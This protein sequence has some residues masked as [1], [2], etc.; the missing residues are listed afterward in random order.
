MSLTLTTRRLLAAF[1]T[2]LVPFLI[3]VPFY[4]RDG[5]PVIDISLFKS[6]MIVVSSVVGAILIVWVF[7][8]VEFGYVREAIVTGIVWLIA[9]WALD[10]IVLVGMFG[11]NPGEWATFI[12]LRYLMIP[13]IVI[14]AGIVA[15]EVLQKREKEKRMS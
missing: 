6:L 15:D 10:L 11:M 2:W 5:T 14:M 4:G 3:A 9:N 13:V 1:L 7:R 12:G 8:S